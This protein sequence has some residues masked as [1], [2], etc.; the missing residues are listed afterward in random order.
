LYCLKWLCGT[1]AP[2]GH[3]LF[4]RPIFNDMQLNVGFTSRYPV[5]PLSHVGL[6][7]VYDS[8]PQEVQSAEII[9]KKPGTRKKL[10]KH[11]LPPFPL[12]EGVLIS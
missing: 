12:I 5:E 1:G 4:D 8:D 7:Y 9:T 3:N 6:G 2:E 11:F 10:T